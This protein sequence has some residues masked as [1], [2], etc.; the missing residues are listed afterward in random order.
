MLFRLAAG[1]V[2]EGRPA[3]PG[4]RN[5]VTTRIEFTTQR[6]PACLASVLGLLLAGCQPGS[7]LPP[8]PP[9]AST[10]YTLGP[11]DQVRIITFGEP[12]LTG[13]FTVEVDGDIAVPLLDAVHAEG[14]TPH[15]LAEQIGGL[16]RSRHLFR[17]P[18]VSVQVVTYRP[19]FVL[20]EVNRPGQYPYQPGM[21]LLSAVAIAGG[22]T[23]RAV[24]GYASVVRK[25]HD[26]PTELKAA[27]D[28]PL[29]PGD[30][31][32]IFERNF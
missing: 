30:V 16:L 21:T 13:E 4:C 26:T 18:S 25:Q 20:G 11:G 3:A 17:D 27:R 29:E 12:T 24:D 14:L 8:L 10:A 19:I 5:R 23:Y 32:T 1:T 2:D 7:G 6:R 22:F 28:A 9:P 15:Q 31:V